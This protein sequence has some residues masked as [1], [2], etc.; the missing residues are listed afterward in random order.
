MD[1]QSSKPTASD[2]S[3]AFNFPWTLY[4]RALIVV[5]I[6][7][8]IASIMQGYF[9][10]ANLIMVYLV[11]NVVV[12]TRY[13]RG[14]SVFTACLSVLAYD[15]FFVEPTLTFAV[16]DSQYILTFLVMLL[17]A[18]TIS[19][20]TVR[21]KEQAEAA[22]ERERRTFTSYEMS[23]EFANS[24]S[25]DDLVNIAIRHI[26]DVFHS[27]IAILL[28]DAEGQLQVHGTTQVSEAEIGVA[29]WTYDRGQPAGW[30]TQALP[31]SDGFYLPLVTSKGKVGV[32]GVYPPPDHPAFTRDQLHLL[33]TFANQTALAIERA[34]LAEETERTQL[35]IETERMRNSLLSSVSHDLRTPL[36]AIT[37]A[38]SGM[39]Q[40]RDTLDPRSREL[41][42][43]AYEEAER[44]NRL[45]GNL[46]E[47]TRLESGTV[48]VEKEWQPLEEVVGS[49]LMRLGHLLDDHPLKTDL[50]DDLPLVP[51]DSILI[52]QVLVN[53]LENAVKYTPVGTPIEL[54]ASA[55]DGDGLSEGAEIL[56]E[57]ADSGGGLPPGQ[58]ERIVDKFYRVRPALTGG[59]G[60]G[61]TICRAI[62]QAHGG[63]MWAVNRSDGGA[64]FR[65]TLPLDGEP[66]EV[67]VEDE[68]TG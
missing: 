35:Q 36:A 66:P 46:L 60:L 7:T 37:G 62:I 25:V 45:V 65:F 47:M 20:M 23:R 68:Q 51:I 3:A 63:H 26:Q 38:A 27:R 2:Q 49:A 34:R 24:G 13:G 16:G 1:A 57:V 4:L 33:E 8:L 53:L 18:L 29:R 44:L 14:A 39:L 43:I 64:A 11:G 48:Q 41:A 55:Q 19:D 31:S 42:Q 67:S 22:H 59:V 50:P 6:C 32:L 28:P 40:N 9:A 54:S 30:G 10:S 52:E 58:E 12:A 15:F 5:I 17:V 21:I 61:L 56:V